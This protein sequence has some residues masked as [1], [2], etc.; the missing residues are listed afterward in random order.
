MERRTKAI[1]AS[2]A[3][4]GASVTMTTVEAQPAAAVGG[5]TN[6]QH[7]ICGANGCRWR[8]NLVTTAPL[9]SG[10]AQN[11]GDTLS[12]GTQE[13]CASQYADMKNFFDNY[14]DYWISGTI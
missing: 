4:V 3:A 2:V 1:A 7:N 13:T 8:G 6:W 11:T 12:M 9:K 14:A 5:V 10:Y